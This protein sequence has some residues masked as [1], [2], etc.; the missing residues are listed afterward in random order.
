M[1]E[2]TLKQGNM[3]DFINKHQN[4]NHVVINT[5]NCEGI[6]GAGLAYVCKNRYGKAYFKEYQDDCLSKKVSITGKENSF[7]IIGNELVYN[8]PTKD[9]IWD[10]SKYGYIESG[11][12]KLNVFLHY[13][14]TLE[15]YYE[16]VH[17]PPL[18]CGLGGLNEK[19]IKEMILAMITNQEYQ[20]II[21]WN[22]S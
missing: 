7:S 10:L 1:K 14:T 3:F 16:Y 13:L 15:T 22:F 19:V 17:I 21:L 4:K 18:G 5:V 12:I 6:M 8:F 2:Y 11:L 9:L 20:K